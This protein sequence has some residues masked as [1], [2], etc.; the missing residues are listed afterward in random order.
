MALQSVIDRKLEPLIHRKIEGYLGE[1]DDDLV[2]FVLEHIKDRKGPGK[3]VDELQSVSVQ[4]IV[5]TDI[6]HI[7][8][9][10]P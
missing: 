3:L 9:T 1:I 7:I 5:Q 6:A 2:M 10:G 4:L 8:W